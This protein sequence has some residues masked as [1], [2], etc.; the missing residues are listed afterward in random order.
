MAR[1]VGARAGLSDVRALVVGSGAVGGRACRQLVQDDSVREVVL[2]GRRIEGS[3]RL[4]RQMGEKVRPV[5]LDQLAGETFDVAVLTVA[6]GHRRLAERCLSGGA[7][8]VS[9]VTSETVVRELLELD[10]TARAASRN[11]VVGAAFA[12]GLSCV[13]ARHGSSGLDRVDEIEV[14]KTGTAGPACE[15][16]RWQAAHARLRFAGLRRRGAARTRASFARAGS[17]AGAGSEPGGKLRAPELVWFPAPLGCVECRSGAFTDELLLSR[18]F[19]GATRVVVRAGDRPGVASRLAWP[20]RHRAE[21]A[22]GIGA[23]R[24]ELRGTIGSAV[25]MRVLGAVDRAS[26]AAGAV[27]AQAGLWAVADRLGAPGAAG[28]AELVVDT[29]GF[30]GELAERGVKAA[31]LGGAGSVAR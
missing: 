1:A 11:L 18:A 14:A 16:E 9:T 10:A 21:R 26:V 6:P 29:V 2:A 30:L 8:V 17:S 20:L 5:L 19:P 4:A 27:S 28:L 15:A 24:V 23:V 22:E 25:E 31:A 13:L 7:H 12:P 3:E